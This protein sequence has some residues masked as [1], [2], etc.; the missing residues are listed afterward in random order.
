MRRTAR[1]LSVAV[2]AGAALTTGPVPGHAAPAV[3]WQA[4]PDGGVRAADPAGDAVGP[5]EAE[6]PLDGEVPEIPDADEPLGEDLAD[7]GEPFGAEP[8]GPPED[9]GE[10]AGADAGRRPGGREPAAEVSP[11]TVEPGAT[12]T[13][14]VSCPRVHGPAPAVLDATSQAFDKGTVTLRKV[15]GDDGGKGAGPAYRGTARVAPAG[16]FE[17][18]P[19]SAGPDTAWTVDG[20][21]PGARGTEGPPWSATFTVLKPRGGPCPEPVRPGGHC[22]TTKPPCPRTVRPGE[23]CDAPPPHGVHAGQ[24]GAFT[25]SVPALVAGGVLIAGALAA[26]AHRLRFRDRGTGA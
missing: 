1:A 20:T 7:T 19:D 17:G 11:G 15:P 8:P 10:P 4:A 2:L 3:R 16:N 24:G 5:A 6:E 14:S 25:D 9:P 21:C 22:G 26:A 18:G 23:P 13:V 12:V